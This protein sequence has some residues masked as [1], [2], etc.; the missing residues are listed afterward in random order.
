MRKKRKRKQNHKTVNKEEVKLID[1]NIV[2]SSE[3][4]KALFEYINIKSIDQDPL[5]QLQK[6]TEEYS[7]KIWGPIKNFTF[8]KQYPSLSILLYMFIPLLFDILGFEYSKYIYFFTWL[9]FL[10]LIFLPLGIALIKWW[11]R[12][13]VNFALKSLSVLFS[14]SCFLGIGYGMTLIFLIDFVHT[15]FEL[16]GK[17][18]TVDY[19]RTVIPFTEW[20]EDKLASLFGGIMFLILICISWGL[21]IILIKKNLISIHPKWKFI[22]KSHYVPSFQVGILP[23]ITYLNYLGA[24]KPSLKILF[25]FHTFVPCIIGVFILFIANFFCYGYQVTEKYSAEYG[26]LLKL[27]ETL[28]LLSVKG[29]SVK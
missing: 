13:N 12:K 18:L 27:K 14:R 7:K 15:Q 21:L 20:N 1:N 8:V 2:L 26:A 5:Y 11:S 3:A 4:L 17:V 10:I 24:E 23:V 29:N 6:T 9:S 22:D 19:I 25:L 28:E 16:V